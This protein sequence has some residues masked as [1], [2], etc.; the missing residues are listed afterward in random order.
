MRYLTCLGVAF[1]VSILACGCGEVDFR[2]YEPIGPGDQ[3]LLTSFGMRHHPYFV[4]D[5]DDQPLTSLNLVAMYN[6][7]IQCRSATEG[8]RMLCALVNRY[9]GDWKRLVIIERL[10]RGGQ[11]D[12]GFIAVAITPDGL[13]G[14]TNFGPEGPGGLAWRTTRRLRAFRVDRTK[15]EACLAE[16][17]EAH[18]RTLYSPF[19]WYGWRDWPVYFLHYIKYEVKAKYEGRWPSMEDF[20][21]AFTGWALL[22]EDRLAIL[23]SAPRDYAKAQGV[24]NKYRVWHAYDEGSEAAKELREAGATYASLLSLVWE[25]TLGQPDH[26]VLGEYPPEVLPGGATAT[27]DHERQH[28]SRNVVPA[29]SSG[30]DRGTE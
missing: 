30:R 11:V 14:V 10:Q 22:P 15:F 12:T 9:F 20:T 16:L 4:V 29:A 21:C 3:F 8:F 1:A 17:D 23:Q 5:P 26:G 24:F 25:S 7:E 6:R 13:R 28:A 18:Q 27:P 19:L 2:A